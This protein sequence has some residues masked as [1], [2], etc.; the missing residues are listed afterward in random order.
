MLI[1]T[2][3]GSLGLAAT[4]RELRDLINRALLTEGAAVGAHQ[5]AGQRADDL[6][7]AV[8]SLGSGSRSVCRDTGTD[9]EDYDDVEDSLAHEVVPLLEVFL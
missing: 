2:G 8:R 3:T 7:G 9:R 4:C 6:A 5:F 1:F